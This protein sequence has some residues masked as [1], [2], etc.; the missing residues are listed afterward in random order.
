[1]TPMRRKRPLGVNTYGYIWSTPAIDC[2]QSLCAI[3]YREF[4]LVI[5]PPHLGLDECD[6]RQRAELRAAVRAEGASV[7]SLNL[8]SLDTNLSSSMASMRAYSVD[9]FRRAIDLASELAAPWL[10]TVP[11]RVSPLLAPSM[12]QRTGWMRES[13]DVLIPHAESRGVGLAIENVPFASFPDAASLGDFVRGIGS[14]SVAVCYDAANAHFIGE[15]PAEGLRG[16][17][18]LVKVV[19]LSD[20]RRSVWRHDE[21]GLGDVP[22]VEVG[23]ALDAIGFTGA[24]MLEII[25]ADPGS[26]IVRSHRALSA[27][28]FAPIPSEATA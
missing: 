2:V 11:G 16:L 1:M 24:S 9:V 6:A 18:D 26:A 17:G 5:H 14:P 3:G 19:H 23:A 27:M 28:G 4:E 13:L 21:I 25:D 12:A 15:A 7:T 22:F 20:T 10:V 8:P